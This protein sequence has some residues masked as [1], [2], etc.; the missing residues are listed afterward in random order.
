M[1]V[2]NGRI[3]I[4]LVFPHMVGQ[5]VPPRDDMVQHVRVQLADTPRREERDLH[6]FFVEHLH[7]APDTDA[8]TELS[9]GPLAPGFVQ[10]APQQHG[11]EVEREV[12]GDLHT[13]GVGEIRDRDTSLALKAR[14]IDKA[15]ERIGRAGLVHSALRR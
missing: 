13:V 7:D 8:A 12:D 5:F 3:G 15:L 11:I 2:F 6:V 14:G 9:L 10:Q 4:N 1:R